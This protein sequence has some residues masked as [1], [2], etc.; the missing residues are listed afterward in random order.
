MRITD[1][2]LIR[3]PH[4]IST[5]TKRAGV[6]KLDLGSGTAR[7]G[8]SCEIEVASERIEDEAHLRE[9]VGIGGGGLH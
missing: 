2:D 4:E 7:R 3:R 9:R 6:I 1:L 5:A 8:S